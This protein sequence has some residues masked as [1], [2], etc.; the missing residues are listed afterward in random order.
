M[1]KFKQLVVVL[2]S[3]SLVFN[4]VLL[5]RQNEIGD[6]VKTINNSFNKLEG[7]IN[8]V[9]H[10][11]NSMLSDM[12][13][14]QRWI[15]PAEVDIGD[16]DLDT[17]ET[18]VN[19]KWQIKDYRQGAETTFFY[20][21]G[22]T[23]DYQTVPVETKGGG[24]FEV[25]VPL[26]LNVEPYWD[27]E[28]YSRASGAKQRVVKPVPVQESINSSNNISY[29]ISVEKDGSIKSSEI[30]SAGLEKI[31]HDLYG[32]PL[33]RLDIDNNKYGIFLNERT[34]GKARLY[35]ATLRVYNGDT[36]V[37][38]LPLEYRE[39][40]RGDGEGYSIQY[41]RDQQNPGRLVII[42][43]YDNGKEFQREIP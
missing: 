25:A 28:V 16:A 21:Q 8:S 31:A 13:R 35:S 22:N 42:A 43:R 33:L 36:L 11:V 17:G 7:A 23:G 14:E 27:I 40:P 39:E 4:A 6:Q 38:E 15:T 32:L 29:Y 30:Q 37:S 5:Y 1:E 41:E 2:L 10:Q 20:R 19:L 18:V 24:Y 26:K 12:A 9:T 3:L 34:R